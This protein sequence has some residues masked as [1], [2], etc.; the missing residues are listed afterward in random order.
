MERLM[1][2]FFSCHYN[3]IPDRSN[4][5][6]KG[7]TLAH[8]VQGTVHHGSEAKEAEAEAAGHMA[9]STVRREQR[10]LVLSSFSLV[11][12]VHDPHP[13]NGLTHRG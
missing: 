1:S 6:K 4:L 5:Q 3:K 11:S 2:S 12:T 7:F 8:M 9:R 10:S 13:G